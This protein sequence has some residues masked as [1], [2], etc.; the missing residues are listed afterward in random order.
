MR[1]IAKEE[2]A[3]QLKCDENISSFPILR[4][5]LLDCLF[6]EYYLHSVIYANRIMEG[7]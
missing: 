1:G 7:L 4:E 2:I 5:Y 3:L 6:L